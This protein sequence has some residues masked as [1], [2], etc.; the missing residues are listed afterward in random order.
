VTTQLQTQPD[1]PAKQLMVQLNGKIDTLRSL[2]PV[3]YQPQAERFVKRAIVHF[4]RKRELAGVSAS[5]FINCVMQAGE[6]GLAIDGRLAHAVPFK[7]GNAL[8]ATLMLDYKGVIVIARRAG[9]IKDAWAR[10]VYQAEVDAGDFEL[11]EDDQGAHIRHK[12]SLLPAATRGEIVGAYARVVFPSGSS[13]F[14]WMSQEQLDQ[15][16]AMSAAY[17]NKKGPWTT[18]VGDGEMRK[19]VVLHRALKSYQDD[20]MLSSL[21]T[22]EEEDTDLDSAERL[23]EITKP[24]PERD[25]PLMDGQPLADAGNGGQDAGAEAHE[26]VYADPGDPLAAADDP[27]AL[28]AEAKTAEISAALDAVRTPTDLDRARRQVEDAEELIRVPAAQAFRQ[29]AA[30]IS[31]RLSAERGQR[32]TAPA[33]ASVTSPPF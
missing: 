6:L 20:P 31:K 21:L 9:L 29:R 4:M 14:E 23:P 24:A 18:K 13:R 27:L 11:W 33:R 7:N 10:L 25:D 16:R 19:K 32:G 28:E 8:E 15:V 30:A 22:V 5:S 2:L 26:L 1:G 3:Q 17:Q 12:I